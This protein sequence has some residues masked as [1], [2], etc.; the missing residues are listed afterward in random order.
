MDVVVSTPSEPTVQFCGAGPIVLRWLLTQPCHTEN[1]GKNWVCTVILF[2]F[3]EMRLNLCPNIQ[4]LWVNI[5]LFQE[6]ILDS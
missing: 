5:H 3:R 4:N 2:S 6:E 1:W